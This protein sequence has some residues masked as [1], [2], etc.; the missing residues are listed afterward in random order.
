MVSVV[1]GL[2]NNLAEFRQFREQK[3]PT[4]IAWV[5]QRGIKR[6][7]LLQSWLCSNSVAAIPTKIRAVK[8]YA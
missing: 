5:H 6:T 8:F 4:G 1:R 2:F 7:F 3:V